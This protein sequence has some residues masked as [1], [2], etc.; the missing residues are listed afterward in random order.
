MTGADIVVA[1]LIRHQVNTVFGYPG[2]NILP[3]YESLRK[4]K[5]QIRHVLSCHEQ[6]AVHAA[7]GFARA[8]GAIGVAIATSGPGATNLVTG[9][10]TAYM[11]SSPLLVLT[12][13]VPL[14]D[15]GRDC[16]QEI[17]IT[18]ITMPI[19][20][21]N[22]I[23][24]SAE[25]I[26]ETIREAIQVANSGRKGPVLVDLP[27]DI[28]LGEAEYRDLPP[29]PI[30]M[31]P[32]Q[33]SHGV[34]TYMDY[35]C[36]HERP[37]ILVGG[38]VVA[39]GAETEVR[40]LCK[41]LDVPVIST[42]MGQ[43]VLS[44]KDEEYLGMIGIHGSPSA[45]EA[46][47]RCDLLIAIGTRFNERV[48]PRDGNFLKNAELL[49]IDVD[50]AEIGKNISPSRYIVGDAKKALGVL[51][52]QAPTRRYTSW[53]KQFVRKTEETMPLFAREVLEFIRENL[54]EEDIVVTDVGNHQMWASEIFQGL[55]SR[56]FLTSGGLGTMGFGMGASIG[57]SAARK[58]AHIVLIT[59]DGSIHM[60]INELATA[61]T[62]NIPLTVVCMNDQALGMVLNMQR[63]LYGEDYAVLPNRKTDLPTVARGFGAGA[64]RL[65][66]HA[67]WKETLKNAL[68]TPHPMFLDCL[69]KGA[70]TNG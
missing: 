6:G 22:Y 67:A 47:S 44:E 53:R 62:E 9:I 64:D 51:L 68:S 34:Q 66:E 7:D 27:L 58:N 23:V 36:A 40:A 21:H 61:V 49:H 26:E 20:K 52:L 70:D 45:K 54:K 42:F 57:A 17:D 11:D 65:T 37:L 24:R 55:P 46:V 5:D 60:N 39:S 31:P 18:G 43:G 33:C 50:E 2:A 69:L 3:V 63:E 8:S 30:L 19:T 28:L 29:L 25:E 13:N 56:R 59:G 14:K 41:L 48:A 15:L 16:F 1:S 12:G 4:K 32:L 35:I 10:A 38:G